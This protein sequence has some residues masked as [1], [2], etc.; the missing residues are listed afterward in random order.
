MSTYPRSLPYFFWLTYLWRRGEEE[1]AEVAVEDEAEESS[2]AEG[3]SEVE[4]VEEGKV[5]RTV[6]KM[7]PRKC[8]VQ[9]VKQPQARQESVSR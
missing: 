9:H 5:L 3:S 1:K 7:T 6:I 8:R 4:V 2:V